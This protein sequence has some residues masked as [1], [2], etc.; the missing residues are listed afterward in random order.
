MDE[1]K[2]KEDTK[3]IIGRGRKTLRYGVNIFVYTFVGIFM[4]LM[5]FFGISQTSIFKDWLRDKV[6]ETVNGEIHGK[7]SIGEI[8]GT[9]FTSLIIKNVSLISEQSD[10]VISAGNIELRTSPLKILFK[11]IYV[12][13]FE[14]KDAKIH[15][16]E[17]SDGQLNLLKIFPPSE[18]PDDTTSSKFPFSIEVADFEMRNVEF[19]LQRFD[20]VGSTENYQSMTT[21][22]LRIKDLNVSFSAFADLNK[23]AYRLTINNIS[24]NP[25]F[26]FSQVQY[27][28]GSILLTPELAGINKL[29][30]I[31][32]D[33]D[34]E[35][36]AAILGV[37]FL[38]DFSIE[39][40]ENAPV[41]LSFSSLKLAVD[42]VTTYV[43]VLKMF[44]GI[45]STELEGS[46][47]FK[48]LSLKKFTINYNNTLLK[49]KGVL[50][51]LLDPDKMNFDIT[52]TDSYVDPSDPNKL[53]RE[54][55]LPEYME[56]GVFK[57]DTL[58]YFGGPLEFKTT[59]AI[60][61]DKGNLNGTANIDLHSEEMVY[62]A[63]LITKNLDI[64]PF[65][66]ISTDMNSEIKISGVGF[67]PQKMKLDFSMNGVSSRFGEK[68][69]NN[70]N[71][72]ANAENGLVK[73]N[74][75]LSSDSTS[76]DLIATLDFNNADD[77]AYE[78]KGKMNGINLAELLGIKSLDSKINLTLD[79]SGQGFNPDSMD[80]FLVT[81]IQNSRF[82]EF[83][84]DSTRLIMDV[85][86]N[87]NGK[88]I[89]NIISDIADF[90]LSGNFQ[91]TTLGN[92]LSREGEIINAAIED[93]IN[94]ILNNDSTGSISS[95]ILVSATQNSVQDFSL[96]YL[97][98]FKQNINL[99]FG[100]S[101][102]ELDG[103]ATGF[104]KSNDD[105]LSI[106][107]NSDFDYLKYWNDKDVLFLINSQLN[108]LLSNHLINGNSG[109]LNAELEFNAERIYASGNIYDVKSKL[110]LSNNEL[111]ISANGKYEDD[112]SAGIIAKSIFAG[113]QIKLDIKKLD[114][115]YKRFN[116]HNKN[117]LE[118]TYSNEILD[119]KK[120]ILEAADG[121]INV[122]GAFG[123][124]GD[125]SITITIDS[126]K[127]E[128]IVQ[129]IIGD[130]KGKKFVSDINIEGIVTGNFSDPRFSISAS[131]KN[132]N[133]D[134]SNFGSLISRF[135]YENNS[136]KTDIRLIDSTGNTDSLS[137]LITG[138]IPLNLTSL[139]D[140]VDNSKK[141]IDLTIES[142]EYDLASL[143]NILPYVQFQ[144]GK[145]ETDIYITGTVSKPVA[146]GYFSINDASLK[147][148][149]NNLDY[150]FS[151]KVWVD[152]EDITI[153][154]VT[155]QNV[156]GT[157]TGGTLKGE[158]FVKLDEFRLDSTFIKVNGD[159][160]IL[161]KIS[162][163]ASPL[164]YGDL[165]IRTRGDIVYSAKR[166][167][168]YL[169]LPIDVTVADLT[170]PLSKSAYSST[171]GFIYKYKEGKT[172]VDQLISELDS[173]IETT[174][175][176]DS[177]RNINEVSR[178]DYTLDIKLATEAEVVVV[179]SKE[180][181][182]NLVAILGGDFFLESIN[183][184]KRSG[185]ELKLLEGSTLSFIKTFEAIGNVKFDK[186][187]NPIIDITSTYRDYYTP[188]NSANGAYEQ[189]VAV[190]IKLRGPLSE[191]NRNFIKDENNI[192]VYMGRQAIEEDKK[193]P[194]KNATD[195]MYFLIIGKFPGDDNSQQDKNLVASTS[196]A[197]A[198]SLL[199]EV[200]NQYFDN[201]IKG[202]QLRQTGTETKFNLLGQVWKIK[203]QIGG[204]TEV[205][206]DLSR[207]NVK[208]EYPI[209]E[210]LQLRLERKES[211]NQTSS[212]NNPLFF[213]GGFKYNFEF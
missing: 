3:K 187:D 82:A 66:S 116:I 43:P 54:L 55:E 124:T 79:A 17:E 75:S 107:L 118:I 151:A 207:A 26:N 164:A 60:R 191:L 202:F 83:N 52:V 91:I 23:Y 77:P 142:D 51:N 114:L 76:A 21:D 188:P 71:I 89:I 65:I 108:G 100:K 5:I 133:Y 11:N 1:K 179:L 144:K 161:D 85:R 211:E 137:M 149:Q 6:V 101:Q 168:S 88:K 10:T 57:I 136:L 181:D 64:G 25:N 15:L 186:L 162:K 20:K 212:I 68:Y 123:L 33:S 170:V 121:T 8:D 189:E 157:S 120:F 196:T 39:K 117:D 87:D 122:N 204:S 103:Q 209:T 125:H 147:L 106:T 134:E 185:G 41:R 131:A 19:T 139:K 176:K 111:D 78:I 140:T 99:I 156:F 141:Q 172:N 127:S 143:K 213:E 98:D 12:R 177:I 167:K 109:N 128:K 28:S 44:D 192:G 35:L 18:K 184:T 210:R 171:S 50:K 38:E 92:V 30:L 183:G 104:I 195:A 138:Y 63:K 24:F 182:Q 14:L 159:L 73:T 58:T 150:N 49:A 40:L 190:K 152:D 126:L 37:N 180:L 13:K 53:L 72:S 145:L 173:L 4:L 97:L 174:N 67:D 110:V 130:L 96:E 7:L 129:D 199:G 86:R 206:Q 62:D 119:F 46:G 36:S 193:D 27:L 9:I 115:N 135:D 34:V 70:I 16:V 80:L 29:H 32:R 203:Y 84:I 94:P 178:F 198:G 205:L 166:G 163:N 22:D 45:I 48:E 146:I 31:T 69:F 2:I 200:L 113:N 61:T 158:G 153:E 56:F 105:S 47:T 165:A 90:T 59:F 154:S 148:T 169:N 81:D 93:K 42:D 155:L 74:L 95:E 132:I 201:Y 208:M 160:K 175:R 112:I 194:T 197:L 102:I